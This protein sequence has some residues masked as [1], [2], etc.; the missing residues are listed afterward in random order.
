MLAL[1][2]AGAAVPAAAQRLPELPQT[3]RSELDGRLAFGLCPDS[4]FDFYAS[5][6]YRP[7]VPRPETVLGYPIGSWHTTYG[8]MEK[9][10]GALAAAAPERVRVFDYGESIERQTMHLVVVSSERNIGRLDDVRAGLARLAD[11]RTT[12]AAQAENIIA[13]LPAVVWLN[14]AN[15]GNETAAFEAALQLAYQLAAGEDAR[16]R[17]M[18]DDVVTVINLAHNPE[19]HERFVAWYN[20]FVMGDANPA[21][22]EHQAPWGMSTNNNHYQFDLNRDAL[23]LTQSETRAV[24]AELQ[25]W[26]PQ[27]FIDLHGQTTQFF[28]PPAADPV[29]PI[30]PEHINRWLDVFGRANAAAFDAH[31][32][33]YF[34]R[35]VFDLYYPGYWDTYP[36]LHGATGMT[37]ETDG[38]GSKGVRW[39]RDDGTILTFADGIAGHFVASLAAVETAAQHRVERLRDYYRF[40]VAG[41]ERGRSSGVRSVVLLTGDN[42]GAAD[43][44]ATTLLRHGIE[45]SRTTA[46][47]T[48][49]G[50]D[51]LTG[52]RA[53]QRVPAGAYV[54][55][56][57]Q[58]NGIIAHTLLAPDIALPESFARQELQRFAR[59]LRRAPGEREGA[60]FYDVT[61]WS[62]PLSQ[63]VSAVWSGAAVSIPA[64]R[65]SLPAEVVKAHGGWSAD[66][67]WQRAGGVNGQA[68]S[69]YVWETGGTGATRLATRLMDEGFAVVVS[70]DPLVVDNRDY[71]RGAFIVRVER[72]APALYERIAVLAREAG[73]PVHAASSAFPERGPTGTGSNATRTL[74]RPRIAV[75]AGEGVG[76]S[77]YGALWFELERRIGLPFTALRAER[78]TGALD[79]F[80]VLVLPDGNYGAALGE[81]ATRAVRGWIERG[82][83][84]IG[85]GGG[86]RWAQGADLGVTYQ[87]ADTT[88][89]ARDSAAA[90][91]RRIDELAPQTDLPPMTAPNAR[92]NDPI[93]VPGALLRGRLDATH[94][95]T[96]GYTTSEIPLLVRA[97]PLRASVRGANPVVFADASRLVIGGFTWPDNT[98]RS[99]AGKTYAT[100]DSSG[101][102]RVILFAFDPLY[103]G[104][105]T[106]PAQLLYN[107]LL[108][109]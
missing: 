23:G 72:N 17:R 29:N 16:T 53:S 61:A 4:T 24:A 47:A 100:V 28:F 104:T 43:A 18:R 6:Q 88:A 84:L 94:W 65:L 66:V 79:D 56:M 34:T 54:I 40:F 10:I 57:A 99:Y 97:L 27:V 50:T 85:Y 71:R 13:Q 67:G 70:S 83:T 73:V 41:M 26:R 93:S 36:T 108:L 98:A 102:G 86:A 105:Y 75:L 51:Y 74:A 7:N 15:D 89:L 12:S 31:G 33:S 68:R 21:A 1:C 42:A 59:N 87:R 35:D 91:L 96:S 49:N 52:G 20:A 90:I 81:E 32:W 30:Y 8:R 77:S 45:V 38:G 39:R 78:A 37:Y 14:A 5:G 22:L 80:D 76:I 64:Q 19:S 48:I 101:R 25:R 58:P 3:C 46:D 2:L 44:L 9:Y 82:G 107:A 60:A 103:R 95:L 69:A 92:I 109:R 11:P 62:L 106:V 63:G 55:D